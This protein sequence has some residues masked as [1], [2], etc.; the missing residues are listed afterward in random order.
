MSNGVCVSSA[1]DATRNSPKPM[2]CV[3]MSGK[4]I[5][6]QPKIEPVL[7]KA[8]MPCRLIVPHWMTTPTT[9]SSS[10]SS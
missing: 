3:R 9:A 10:G 6:L 1:C 7:W 5:P 4:P 8:T 2:N